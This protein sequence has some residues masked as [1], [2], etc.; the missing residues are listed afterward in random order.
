MKNIDK[1][2]TFDRFIMKAAPLFSV[3]LIVIN[4]VALLAV[5]AGVLWLLREFGV[6]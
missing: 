6:I 4:V 2:F 3:G 5:V 1:E